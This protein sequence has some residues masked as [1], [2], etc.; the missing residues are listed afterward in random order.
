LHSLYT[1]YT[2]VSR[3][4]ERFLDHHTNFAVLY[5]AVQRQ[6]DILEWRLQRWASEHEELGRMIVALLMVVVIVL[7]V[8]LMG[9]C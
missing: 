4:C 1:T 3:R 9:V 6:Q 2:Q 8:S 7:F 5:S